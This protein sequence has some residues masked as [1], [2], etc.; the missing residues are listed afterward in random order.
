MAPLVRDVTIG[1]RLSEFIDFF[2]ALHATPVWFSS[3][4][5][6]YIDVLESYNSVEV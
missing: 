6:F 2:D 1:Y 3:I 5:V 4:V